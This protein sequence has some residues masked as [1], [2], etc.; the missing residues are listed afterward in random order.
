MN[1]NRT[2]ARVP[3]GDLAGEELLRGGVARGEVELP[4]F[5]AAVIRRGR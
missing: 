1:F 5:G 3:L 4:P 2:P